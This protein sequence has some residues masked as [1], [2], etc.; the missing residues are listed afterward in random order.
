MLLSVRN[1]WQ[2]EC[3]ATPWY[4]F[5]SKCYAY[6][7]ASVARIYQAAEAM[8]SRQSFREH[9]ILLMATILKVSHEDFVEQKL[10][11]FLTLIKFKE[12]F[13]SKKTYAFELKITNQLYLAGPIHLQKYKAWQPKVNTKR[14]LMIENRAFKVL[15]PVVDMIQSMEHICL[16]RKLGLRSVPQSLL[17]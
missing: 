9:A 3:T 2:V 17:P 16:G 4:I 10:A 13:K 1:M 5:R 7:A 14:K 8:T 6:Q 15:I 12:F 11:S